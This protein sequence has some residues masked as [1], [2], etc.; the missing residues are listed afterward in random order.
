[1]AAALLGASL[2]FLVYNFNPATI[3]RGD[4]GSL[5]LGFV[6]AA[7][8]M[9]IVSIWP[10]VLLHAASN[11]LMLADPPHRERCRTG[12]RHCNCSSCSSPDCSSSVALNARP[13]DEWCR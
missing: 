12:G 7:L 9:Q 1:M 10:L 8:R 4:A 5:F 13:V 6:L 3:I 2:G 11:L